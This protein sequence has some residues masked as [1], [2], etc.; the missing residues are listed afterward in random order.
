MEFHYDHSGRGYRT[1]LND[2]AELHGP[3]GTFTEIAVL[4]VTIF[5]GLLIFPVIVISPLVR[6]VVRSIALGTFGIA[7]IPLDVVWQATSIV[8]VLLSL[9]WLKYP[10]LRPMLLIPG[11]LF[12][13]FG[14]IWVTLT[15][16]HLPMVR[17]YRLAA[18]D[19]WPSTY[20]VATKIL[21][22]RKA[23]LVP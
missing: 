5:T 13:T 16:S 2:L 14:T 20:L 19:T 12:A 23:G 11:L 15:T 9:A 10:W 21:E 6:F 8:L 17:A 7:A 4:L 1:A 3:D 22:D 18:C